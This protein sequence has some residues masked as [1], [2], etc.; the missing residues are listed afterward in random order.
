MALVNY[1]DSDRSEAE[2]DTSKNPSQVKTLKR[3]RTASF[4]SELPPLP[5]A[6]HDLYASTTRV[7]SQDDP[8]LHGGRQRVTPHVEGN[9]PTH[10][11][12][13][14]KPNSRLLWSKRPARCSVLLIDSR[15]SVAGRIGQTNESFVKLAW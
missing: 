12:I 1:S 13:E 5:D 9:W 4:N 7:S 2:D 6:F 8:I 3:K 10:V 11:Y 14:C 15:V